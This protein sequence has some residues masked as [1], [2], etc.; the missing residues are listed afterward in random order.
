MKNKT[1]IMLGRN[2]DILNILPAIEYEAKLNN[3]TPKLIVAKDYADVLDG[4]SYVEK[5]VFDDSFK[6]INEAL[7]FARKNFPDDEIINCAIYG[8]DFSIKKEC[9]S[10][11]RDSWKLSKCPIPWGRLPLNF[12][13][14]SKQREDLIFS[15][16]VTKPI[17]LIATKGV[18]SP[19]DYASTMEEYLWD[20]L[21]SDFVIT[22]ISY[23]Q[24][25][26]IFDLL[27]LYESAHCLIATDSAPLHL[28][29]AVPNLPV[30]S[31]ITDKPDSWHQSSWRSN[32]ILRLLYSEVPNNLDKIIE[33]VR[34]PK[35]KK[36]IYFI[37]SFK[38]DMD[39]ETKR[40]N[41]LAFKTRA[42]EM[43]YAGVYECFNYPTGN[44]KSK[45]GMPFVKDMINY[46]SDKAA[47]NDIL[48]ICN[49]D[50]CF[51]PGITGKVLH[52]VERHGAG[53]FHRW[54]MRKGKIEKP[55]ISE[56]ELIGY[57]W[58][59]GSDTFAFTK[60]WWL[61]NRSIFPDM[62]FGREWWDNV[63]RN[64]IKKTNGTE[65]H[66]AIYH[67]KHNSFWEI[68]KRN[69]P[70]NAYNT[71]LNF[72]W[73]NQFGGLEKDWRVKPEHWKGMFK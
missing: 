44:R 19:F 17:L 55:L 24:S 35:Q 69:N 71:R 26:R 6:N 53:Y 37:T 48:M 50:I 14:R 46:I 59:D 9:S 28:A 40:R 39:G 56:S 25:F 45:E 52:Q 4:C 15:V 3:Y 10:F 31:L 67:E 12:D 47:D 16:N 13:N 33:A 57:T 49:S 2:G 64:L 66:S 51:I 5:V 61:E 8:K 1:Y 65:I 73:K 58:Y 41:E 70:G 62:I 20:V 42:E 23:M 30:I 54:D 36:K 43:N 38:P 60:K 21:S 68:N 11:Q 29:N 7:V 63:F 34:E 18:S 32:H 72:E 22:N 27:K